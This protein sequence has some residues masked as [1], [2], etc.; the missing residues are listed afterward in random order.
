MERRTRL[1]YCA[2]DKV[3]SRNAEIYRNRCGIVGIKV[4]RNEQS[5][6][7]T[8]R[9]CMAGMVKY[10]DRCKRAKLST[11]TVYFPTP[12]KLLYNYK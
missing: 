8:H 11:Q 7:D 3:H 5:R 6:A 9:A 2:L 1:N 10:R 12:L 4:L